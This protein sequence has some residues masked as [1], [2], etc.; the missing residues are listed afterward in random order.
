MP[1]I[2]LSI[3]I[4]FLLSAGTATTLFGNSSFM[5]QD[6]NAVRQAPP[7]NNTR[8]GFDCGLGTTSAVTNSTGFPVAPIELNGG[9][10]G[11]QSRC[12]W[13]GDAGQTVSGSNDGTVEPL[14][15]DQD[16]SL[17]LLSPGI[18][19]GFTANVVVFQNSTSTMNGF[20]LRVIWN[21]AVLRLVGFDQTGLVWKSSLLLTP[22]QTIDN[23]IGVA[24]LAQ[25]ISG[26]VSN[27]L[28]I[29]RLRFD[30]VG[31]GQSTLRLVD[32]SGGLA[33][34]GPVTH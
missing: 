17:S 7:S 29:F 12:N 30:I 21:T 6:P 27:N 10:S 11:L 20:D 33:N 3:L 1:R 26:T 8:V 32:V 28:T 23:S 16:E 34:P 15:N 9:S 19:G 5:G 2:A 22:V 24:E 18:G 4:L 25:V 14:V 13:I 31:V